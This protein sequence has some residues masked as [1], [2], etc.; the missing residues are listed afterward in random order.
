MSLYIVATPIGNLEDITLRALRI[1]GEAE[2]ILAED[3]RVIRKLLSQ[4]HI[5]NKKIE[6]YNE[7]SGPERDITALLQLQQGLTIALV[8]DAGTPGI[9]DPGSRLVAYVRENAPEI[10]IIPIPGAS[11]VA[12]IM[13]VAGIRD[14]KFIFHGFPPHKKGR[15]TLFDTIAQKTDSTHILYESPHRILKTLASIAERQPNRKVLVGRELTKIHEE[16]IQKSA[17]G[18]VEY[19]TQHPD[20]IR[21]EFILVIHPIKEYH[22]DI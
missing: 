6:I 14:T 8:T 17:T 10:S 4:Y 2:I 16:I 15:E 18:M 22:G 12:A 3:T 5:S 19:F 21:G 1:L 7:H 9:S 11:G 20:H 13:S